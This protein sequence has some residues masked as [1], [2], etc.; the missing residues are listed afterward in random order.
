MPASLEPLST[1]K[2]EQ[3]FGVLA[4]AEI[5][6]PRETF[7]VF[8]PLKPNIFGKAVGVLAAEIH[9]EETFMGKS[10]S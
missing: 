9:R 7:S 6:C 5:Q 4:A 2:L 1:S 10:F 3:A 8:L